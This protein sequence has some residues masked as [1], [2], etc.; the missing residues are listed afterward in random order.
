MKYSVLY[1]LGTSLIPELC[2]DI[3]AGTS[4]HKEGVL[5]A[6][7]TVRTLP[8]Q[9]AV[10]VCNYL[11]LSVLAALFTVVALGVELGVENVVVYESHNFQNC[12]NIVLKVRHLNVDYGTA[13]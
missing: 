12:I 7:A 5:V 6:V 4:C 8:D 2:S 11:D 1:F 10:I 3:S 9:F 13:R